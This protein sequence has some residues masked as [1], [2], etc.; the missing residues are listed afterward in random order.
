MNNQIIYE[1][2]RQ[3][4]KRCDL[5]KLHNKEILITGASGL[6]GTYLMYTLY[7]GYLH[8]YKPRKVYAVIHRE[9][10]D[11]LKE[12]DA[13]SWI[14]FIQGNLSDEN[15]C[16][17]LPEADFIIHA[18]G[19]GQPVKFLGDPI[20]AIRQ[21][22]ITTYSLFSKL[23]QGGSFLFI[24][25]CA[26]YTDNPSTNCTENDICYITLNHPRL[27]YIEGKRCGEAICELYR[28]QG[29]DAKIV[30]LSFTY[31]PG[32]RYDDVR[33]LYEFIRKGMSGKIN[34]RDQGTCIHSYEY[35]SDAV[36]EIW[37]IML[38]GKENLY[39]LV[40]H[41]D[42]TI[43]DLASKIAKRLNAEV[44]FPQGDCVVPGAIV[45]QHVS[46]D[47]VELEFGK[48][49]FVTLEKGLQN[50]LDW[51]VENYSGQIC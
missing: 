17:H 32:V 40:G 20:S 4:I 3:V 25:S 14:E 28:R 2:A 1:D 23:R 37:N 31:G 5:S 22:T 38:H 29:I 12:F 48:H 35:I 30:R 9:I 8:G 42:I 50:T 46:S 33:V 27:C 11:Y 41:S 43:Y 36:E 26:L 44:I 51:F 45:Q 24:S 49:D 6:V 34:M 19:Y 21:N 47:R 18:S 16:N 15:F 39:N 10:P 7:A 13:V